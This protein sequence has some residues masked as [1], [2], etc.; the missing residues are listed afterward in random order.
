MQTTSLLEGVAILLLLL[1]LA[2]L[3]ISRVQGCVP[4]LDAFSDVIYDMAAVT[5]F[6]GAT[7]VYVTR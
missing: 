6:C 1:S 5:T 2:V 3:Q 4:K 7:L